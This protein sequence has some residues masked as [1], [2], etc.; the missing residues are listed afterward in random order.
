MSL[1]PKS[2][3][4]F[5]ANFIEAHAGGVGAMYIDGFRQYRCMS[6]SVPPGKWARASMLAPRGHCY[7][8]IGGDSSAALA[9]NGAPDSCEMMTR[10]AL[11]HD[12]EAASPCSACRASDFWH[13]AELSCGGFYFHLAA[14][15]IRVTRTL[16][17][18]ML[19]N[20]T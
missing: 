7:F 17:A 9:E 1:L 11:S 4:T 13:R 18:P 15:P 3:L 19:S 14:G 6:K 16:P 8:Q 20:T 12:F 10:S 5:A 2:I